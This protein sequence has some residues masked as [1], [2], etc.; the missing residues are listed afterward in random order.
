M[1][2]MKATRDAFGEALVDL[3]KTNDRVVVLS[4]DL[5][6]ATRANKFKKEF[7]G[8]FFNIGIAEQD[9]VGTSTGL[10][11][12]G[13]IPFASS[14]AVFLTSRAYGDIRLSV[15]YNN[16]NVKLCGS[17]AGL[18]VGEDG[19]SAQAL[20]DIA[21][22]RVLPNM[23]VVVPCDAN[24]TKRAVSFAATT[25]YPMYIRLGR[26]AVPVIT[27]ESDRFEIG[28]ANILREGTD[29]A[30]IA[31]GIM[32]AWFVRVVY[33]MSGPWDEQQSGVGGAW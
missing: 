27:K 28:K 25:D 18:T 14:F 1:V 17:H 12:E 33:G 11:S 23:H 32:V 15:C 26:I 31:C 5:E 2:V 9:L 20:E 24:E 22:M 7:P 21:I 6:D 19:A 13:F 16:R 4:G 8:R 30:I 3:G 29:V 10:G